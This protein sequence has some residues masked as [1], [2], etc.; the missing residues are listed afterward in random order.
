M[1]LDVFAPVGPAADMSV[2]PHAEAFRLQRSDQWL[3]PTPIFRL[4]RD[5][6]VCRRTRHCRPPQWIA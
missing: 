5:E 3:D 1:I 2:P 4:I 6:D